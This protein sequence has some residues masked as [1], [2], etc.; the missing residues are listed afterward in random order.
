MQKN[1]MGYKGS[2]DE[3]ILEEIRK[4]FAEHKGIE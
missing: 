1:H 3:P 4:I 2:K